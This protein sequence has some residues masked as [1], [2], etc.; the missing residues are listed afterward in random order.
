MK[1]KIYLKKLHRVVKINSKGKLDTMHFDMLSIETIRKELPTI[2]K[3]QFHMG[4]KERK[5]ITEDLEKV[6]KEMN[7]LIDLK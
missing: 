1:L 5:K 6:L 4:A 7:K 3:W 2:R